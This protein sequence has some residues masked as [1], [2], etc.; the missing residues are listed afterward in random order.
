MRDVPGRRQLERRARALVVERYDWSAV[1]GE[2]EQALIEF[3]GVPSRLEPIPGRAERQTE[4]RLRNR[5]I[6]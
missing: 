6:S 4:L 1:A 5:A 2:L 3:A